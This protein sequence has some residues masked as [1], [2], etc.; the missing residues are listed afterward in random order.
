M[1]IKFF[2]KIFI[3]QFYLIILSSF[4]FKN[5]IGQPFFQSSF[6]LPQQQWQQNPYMYDYQYGNRQFMYPPPINNNGPSF[7]RGV[8][9]G[10]E[11]FFP[12]HPPTSSLTL[13]YPFNPSTYSL[14]RHLIPGIFA[15]YFF[16]N[17]KKLK[18]LIIITVMERQVMFGPQR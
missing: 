15:N 1:K 14:Q 17:P 9:S 7:S 8:E 6:W 18:A 12:R 10:F 11:T 3:F 13:N 5:L 16:L 2:T 4:C